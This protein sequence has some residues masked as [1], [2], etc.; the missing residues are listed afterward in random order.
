MSNIKIFVSH[1][2]DLDAETVQNDIFVPVRCGAVFDNRENISM[3]GDDTGDNISEKRASF[4]ELTVQYW[5]WKNVD[6]DYYGLC[7]YRRYFSFSNKKYQEDSFNN[8]IDT[9]I[10]N[11]N[12][13][14]YGLDRSEY[15]KEKI[16]KY[17][18]VVTDPFEVKNVGLT[19]LREQYYSQRYLKK[20]DINILFDAIEKLSPEYSDV[21]MR[22]FEGN[23]FIP[24]CMYIMNKKYFNMYSEWLYKILF[25]VEKNLDLNYADEDRLR[26]I[27]HI[28]ERLLGIFCEYVKNEVKIGYLQ[29]VLFT[30]PDKKSEL[31]QINDKYITVVLSS[32]DFFVPYVACTITS[33]LDNSDSNRKYQIVILNNKITKENK[34]KI[35]N[36]ETKFNNGR[37]EFFDIGVLAEEYSFIANNHISVESFYRLFIPE[38]FHDY[39]KVIFLDSDMIIKTD[40][41]KL[42][43]ESSNNHT[44]TAIH[45]PD[46]ESQYL[47]NESIRRYT[48]DTIGIT[49]VKKYFQAGIFVFNLKRFR[50]KYS[51]LKLLDFA[52]S[53]K[54]MYM[55]QDIM[56]S[57]FKD[58]VHYVSMT[59][60]VLTDCAGI[61]KNNIR[62]Y[63]SAKTNAEYLA[64]RKAPKVIHYAGFAKPWDR[65]ED[66][67][68]VDFW[69]VARKTDFYEIIL[70][71]MIDYRT[72]NIVNYN[73]NNKKIHFIN[74]VIDFIKPDD[75]ERRQKIKN[76]INSF[77]SIFAPI[78]SKR[79]E[80]LKKFYF[81]LRGW[82]I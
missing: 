26:V 38:I 61:R 5:A 48:N 55:D 52:T 25:E 37:I 2:I 76:K 44:I 8:V 12:I 27:G 22:Y 15:I 67:F 43:E 51:L 79:R 16:Q 42:L 70:G 49:D 77:V 28:G 4:C 19:N 36:I 9:Y 23:K 17:D 11:S 35:K 74:S 45:D 31:S 14:K 56:N 57:F 46:F 53:R 32:S 41:A 54:F 39:D 72:W 1:R 81:K 75:M 71:R 34:D 13:K 63:A 66:D 60:N 18:I 47:S 62:M 20:E 80:R 50:Q 7:H 65:P 64:A 33:I 21:A 69:E 24:C 59:W 58:D 40:I 6:A 68:A 10:S 30:K 3:L 29:R 73:Q 82:P 78:A